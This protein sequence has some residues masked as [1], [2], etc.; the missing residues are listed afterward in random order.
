[1]ALSNKMS[2]NSI[3]MTLSSLKVAR[4]ALSQRFEELDATNYSQKEMA[5]T[6]SWQS[7]RLHEATA[8]ENSIETLDSQIKWLTAWQ[9]SLVKVMVANKR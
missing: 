5:E 1:M 3:E 8:I 9:N 7:D 2:L 4:M 6:A